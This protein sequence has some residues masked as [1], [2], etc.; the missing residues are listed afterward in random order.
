MILNTS[1]TKHLKNHDE[2]VICVPKFY[3]KWQLEPTLWPA[4]AEERVKLVCSLSEMTKA[5][6]KAGGL[7]DWGCAPGGWSGYAISE[8]RSETEL[9]AGLMKFVPYI[10]FEVMPVLTIDQSIESF[11]KAV[12]TAKK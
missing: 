1:Y 12:A 6:L 2:E 11:N 8:V 3:I 9:N 10:H 4:K 7:K 5:D